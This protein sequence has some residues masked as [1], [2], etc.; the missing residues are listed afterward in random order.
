MLIEALQILKY[1]LKKEHLS[2]MAGWSMPESVMDG[3]SQPKPKSNFLD[4]L[5]GNPEVTMDKFLK[6]LT[7]YDS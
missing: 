7:I 6:E 3:V 5:V 2:F 4:D 1:S